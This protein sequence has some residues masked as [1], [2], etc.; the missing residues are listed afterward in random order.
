MISKEYLDEERV[1][2]WKEVEI[3]KSDLKTLSDEISKRP[4]EL[5]AEARQAAK[6]T[7][8]YRNRALDAKEAAE[9]ALG[10]IKKISLA[11]KEAHE[12]SLR[13]KEDV[14]AA[15]SASKE[16]LE[17]IRLFE[18]KS[19]DMNSLL[20]NLDEYV[21]LVEKLKELSA[22]GTETSTK[23]G[24]LHK[25]ISKKKEEV[26]EAHLEIF[27]YNEN[28]SE[29]G[30]EKFV[31]GLQ[32]ELQVAY[33]ELK[34]EIESTQ[35]TINTLINESQKKQNS[36]IDEQ[37]KIVTTKISKWNS[38]H[39]AT[40]QKIKDL[41]PDAMTAGLSHAFS[42]KRKSEI[43]SGEA[44]NKIFNWSIVGLVTVSLIPFIVNAYLLTTGKDL[45]TII[46][47]SPRL[48]AA[49]IPLY[50]PL[51]WLAYS[52]NK[53]SNLSKRLVEEYTHKEVLSKTF[54]GLSSQ[55]ESI[56]KDSIS[57]ELRI[58]LLYNLL[59]V[60]AENPGKLISNY[61]TSDHPLID[62]LETSSKLNISISKLEKIPGMSRITKILE[63]R[64]SDV[65]EEQSENIEKTLKSIDK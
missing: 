11:T 36:F 33:D 34:N 61:D 10:Q 46:Y 17:K 35:S 14:T 25:A 60:S 47:E 12:D 56:E 55:I 42:E 7:S 29:T 44:L 21:G 24:L 53:K 20:S 64:S 51:V 57:T 31:P 30:L 58:K 62:A 65:L 16:V 54:E 15:A 9:L 19:E 2:L 5:E 22:S 50:I 23:I 63:K 32:G 52:S 28:D 6:K 49:I 48:M 39:S 38:E 45:E 18:N 1:K 40:S 26:E 8:E 27:G 59:D 4:P 13:K 3:I 43:D 41:L 37:S